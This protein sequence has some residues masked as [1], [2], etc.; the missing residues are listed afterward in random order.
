MPKADIYVLASAMP[1]SSEGGVPDEIVYMPEGT[2]TVHCRVNFEAATRSIK[3]GPELLEPMQA[4]LEK[5]LKRNVRPHGGFDHQEGKA[6]F[7]PKAFRY[8]PGRGLMLAVEWTRAGR[9]AVEGRDY[10]YFSPS[11]IT[12]KGKN[13]PI[14]LTEHGE[15]GSL[16]NNPAFEQIERI[17]ASHQQSDMENIEELRAALKKAGVP[18]DEKAEDFGAFAESIK[19]SHT[20][21]VSSAVEAAVAEATKDAPE[22]SE[23]E[24]KVERLEKEKGELAE[25]L[26]AK[27]ESEATS[28]IDEAI[29]AG[30]IAP[31]DEKTKSFWKKTIL[32]GD[33]EAIEALRAIPASEA[34]KAKRAVDTDTKGESESTGLERAIKAHKA[35]N[36]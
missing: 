18:F 25:Q 14:G 30:R 31:Q 33:A 15:I 24:Q 7:I 36:A 19:A 4:S 27:R 34:L 21:E 13:V 35:E 22:K 6:S 16:V 8:E 11:F 9:E 32:A 3:I 5:R 20:T 17:A 1:L 12:A 26:A 28:A 10:S 2:H 29:K 23:L